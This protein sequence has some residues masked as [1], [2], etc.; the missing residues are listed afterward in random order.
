MGETGD[1]GRNLGLNG[2]VKNMVCPVNL[3][4]ILNRP[5]RFEIRADNGRVCR[6][7]AGITSLYGSWVLAPT[8]ESDGLALL[9]LEDMGMEWLGAEIRGEE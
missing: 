8:A 9:G 3:A 7:F 1:S 6:G 2:S 4:L 5:P